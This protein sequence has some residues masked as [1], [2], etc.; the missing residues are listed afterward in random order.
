MDKAYDFKVLVSMVTDRVKANG[1]HVAEEAVEAILTAGYF[2][3]KDW[4]KESAKLSPTKVD[5]FV[6]AFYDQA[7]GYVLP[8]ITKID[9]DGDGK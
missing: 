9:L 5:D 2:A 8:Q 1:L 3:G 6:S 4:A 7:D